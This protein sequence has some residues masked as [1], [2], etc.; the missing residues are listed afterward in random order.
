MAYFCLWLTLIIA[1]LLLNTG[2]MAVDEQQVKRTFLV[3][4]IFIYETVL[5]RTFNQT[6]TTTA[7]KLEVEI[8]YEAL[9]GD[10]MSFMRKLH[11]VWQGRKDFM[12]LKLVP[13]GKAIV[14][15]ANEN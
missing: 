15:K 13:Y 10:S 5:G 12:D 11:N 2:T 1:V 6:N 7:N 14:S 3:V 4:R 9:C 8:F